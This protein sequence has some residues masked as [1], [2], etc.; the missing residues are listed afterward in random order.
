MY[1]Y[2]SL[3]LSGSAPCLYLLSFID[4]VIQNSKDRLEKS[5]FDVTL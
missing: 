4:T 3:S 2:L 1:L 5:D